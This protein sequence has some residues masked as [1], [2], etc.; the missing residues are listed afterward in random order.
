M[1]VL[2]MTD[3]EGI[4][5][6][7]KIE[8]VLE[9]GSPGH[10][11]A[12]ERLMLDVNAAVAG[13]FEGG[14]ANVYVVDG[15]NGAN[16][17]I[18]EMLDSRAIQLDHESWQEMI[19]SGKIGAYME[20][21]AHAM[22]GTINGFLDHTQSSQR[23]YN[24][25]VNG[26]RSGEIAQGA[27]FTGA[28]DVPFVMV[29]GDEAACVEAKGFLGNIECAVVKYGIGRNRA[30]LVDLDEALERIKTAARDS[31][32]LTGKIKPYKPLMP[33]EIRLELY[34]TDMC[35]DLVKR[36]ENV[37]RI[38][39]RTVRKIVHRINSYGDILF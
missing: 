6:I 11:F 7:D 13:A 38:D 18:K 4:S 39:A 14:A 22:A 9:I 5:G 35:D 2:I 36:C 29:S 10:K 19:R 25:I 17:F 16:N 28:F 37:E 15:H 30:R 1:N 27:I 23:W 3:L 24:Y 32:K 21:G 33:L 20:V 31:L 34:R 26:R 12:L 8:M